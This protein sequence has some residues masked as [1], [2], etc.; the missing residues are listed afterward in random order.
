MAEAKAKQQQRE[1][2]EKAYSAR[3][4]KREEKIDNLRELRATLATRMKTVR[5]HCLNAHR[6]AVASPTPLDVAESSAV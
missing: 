5:A 6:A 4:S 3:V 1:L 2:M